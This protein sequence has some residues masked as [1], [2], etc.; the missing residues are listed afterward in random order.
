MAQEISH[1]IEIRAAVGEFIMQFS[2]MELAIKSAI[3]Y[4]FG[5]DVRRTLASFMVEEL[6]VAK[7]L[8]TLD[9]IMRHLNNQQPKLV[10][11]EHLKK[12]QAAIRT[13]HDINTERVKLVH[14]LWYPDFTTSAYGVMKSN[15]QSREMKYD[16]T[17]I[18]LAHIRK[19]LKQIETVVFTLSDLWEPPLGPS[20]PHV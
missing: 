7:Q 10:S 1:D 14:G 18:D 6:D 4:Y 2:V 8:L 11:D 20:Y 16:M 5:N 19:L 15:R 17:S 13:A 9:R 12:T 3:I